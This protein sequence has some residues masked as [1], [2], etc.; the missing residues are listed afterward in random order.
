LRERL[1][2]YARA[3]FLCAVYVFLLASMWISTSDWMLAHL[4]SRPTPYDPKKML[5]DLGML[6][7]S[8]NSLV[9]CL[10]IL[11][12]ARTR[13]FSPLGKFLVPAVFGAVG[14]LIL[15]AVIIGLTGSLPYVADSGQVIVPTMGNLVYWS[16]SVV[17]GFL[18]GQ[19]FQFPRAPRAT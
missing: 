3:S 19:L 1:L 4:G 6:F 11:L 5:H 10:T 17:P 14:T 16:D 7:V 13:S 15:G 8:L 12:F 2:R 9:F 18:A